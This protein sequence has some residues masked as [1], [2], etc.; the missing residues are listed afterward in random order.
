V[1]AVLLTTED[2]APFAAIDEAKAQAMIDDVTARAARVAP[3]I[4]EPD[5]QH[6]AAAVAIL[7]G[8]VLRWHEA[9]SGALQ[10]ASVDDASFS[11][12]NRQQ[13]RTLFWPSEITELQALCSTEGPSGAFAVD[14]VGATLEQHADVC[15]LRFGAL[16]CS[17]GAVLTMNLPLYENL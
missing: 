15:A 1:A 2:L 12:D 17:C 5:F 4:L 3:C 9:G 8:V 11:F 6:D 7:R 13:R 14:T 10:T 16:Y